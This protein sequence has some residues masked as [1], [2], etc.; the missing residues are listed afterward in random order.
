VP[1]SPAHILLIED[2]PAISELM[3]LVFQDEGY[4]VT[5]CASPRQA[6]TLLDRGGFDLVVTDGFSKAPEAVAANTAAV[7]RRAG[8]T[9]VALFTA[10]VIDLAS[11]KAV[12]FRDLIAKPFDLSTVLQQVQVL[13]GQ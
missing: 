9:P 8:A 2:D 3:E 1:D 13:L 10:H 4:A 5:V 11:A 12:G 7:L 6:I